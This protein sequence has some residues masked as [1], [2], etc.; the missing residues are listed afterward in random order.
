MTGRWISV[1]GVEGAGKTTLV[2]ELKSRV[3][4][5]L[6]VDE[7]VDDP[8]GRFLQEIVR[9]HPHVYSK[10]RVGQSLIFLGEFWQRYDL[11]IRP[12]IEAGLTVISDRG[13]LSKHV[14]QRVVME[15]AIGDVAAETIVV[16]AL[17][18]MTLP[19]LT[20]VL[21]APFDV[22]ERRLL[23]RDESCDDRRKAFI[24]KADRI[25]ADHRVLVGETRRFDTSQMA[26]AAIAGAALTA[27]EVRE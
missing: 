13:Y 18:P 8:V 27:K 1:D 20:I 9:Q 26:P 5:A 24:A 25:F 14:Y 17:G 12:S 22:I 15:A 19:D 6:V 2:S 4:D 3:P 21:S 16:G 23:A 10:S 11:L 7:F